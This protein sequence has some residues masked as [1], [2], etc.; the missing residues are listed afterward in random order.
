[1]TRHRSSRLPST[2]AAILAV[3]A[4]A[5]QAVSFGLLVLNSARLWLRT[6]RGT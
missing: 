3:S 5:I 6:R 4:L 2:V 1:M